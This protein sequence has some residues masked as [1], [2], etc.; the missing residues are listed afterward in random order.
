MSKKTIDTD[1]KKKLKIVQI[2]YYSM[3]VEV[4]TKNP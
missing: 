3:K 4:Y 2:W 1:S